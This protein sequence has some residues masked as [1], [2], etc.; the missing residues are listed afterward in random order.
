VEASTDLVSWVPAVV[1]TENDTTFT[2]REEF[3]PGTPGGRFL[4]VRATS[5]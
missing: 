3:P 1:V 2:A 4:R 5:E